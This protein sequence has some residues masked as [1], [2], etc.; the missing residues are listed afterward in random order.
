MGIV[1]ILILIHKDIIEAV[2]NYRENRLPLGIAAGEQEIHVHQDIVIV[3]DAGCFHELLILG[4]YTV[5]LSL[6][7]VAV[8]GKGCGIT[9]V[10]LGRIKVVLGHGNASE[11]FLWL[12]NLVIQLHFLDAVLYGADGVRGV[13]DGKF[14]R[15]PQDIGV[16]P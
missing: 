6:P 9:G 3:H 13:V 7:G 5:N 16:F 10:V 2:C 14:P 1:C 15:I 4:V 8:I 11:H 12:V